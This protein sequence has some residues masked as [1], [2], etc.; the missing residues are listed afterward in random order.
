MKAAVLERYNA[1]LAVR[2]VPDPEVPADGVVL[3]VLACGVCRSDWHAWTGADAD[4]AL[5]IIPGHEYCGVVEAVGRDCHAWRAGDRAVAPFVLG[6]GACPACASGEATTCA[7]QAVPGFTMDGAFA[8]FIAVPR[9]DF[10]LA[11][12]P[13]A[14]EPHAAAGLGCRVTT[15]F[16]ALADRARL[17][18]GE[19]LAVHGCGGV[20]LSAIMLGRAM[21]ARVVA[22]DIDAGKLALARDFGAVATVDASG[23][24]AGD[25]VREAT[26]GGAHVSIEALG[27]NATFDASVRSL[28]HLGRHVQIGMPTGENCRPPL[29][30]DVVYARQLSLHGTRGMPAHRFGDLF[31][32][33]AAAGIDTGALVTRRIGLDGASDALRDLTTFSGLGVTVIDRFG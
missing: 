6:C 15:A 28:R 25:A 3:R 10:N 13:E 27:I 32:L 21:G 5:P 11:R 22:V 33:I 30:L 29:P 17:Q 8:E 18:P 26:S 1:D 20:G 9:A 19:W 7:T 23:T 4:V 14:I 31:G 24:D 2:S 12:M 16:R